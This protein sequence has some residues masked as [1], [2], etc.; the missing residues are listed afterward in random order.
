MPFAAADGLEICYETFDNRDIGLS[1]K[2]ESGPTPKVAAAMSGDASSAAYRLADMADAAGLLD[3]LGI[4]KAHI[5]G[6][7]MGGMIVQAI[8]IKHLDRVLSM[9]SIMSTTGS[10]DVGQASPEVLAT[11][12]TRPAA[13][14]PRATIAATIRSA[15]PDSWS[16]SSPP[17]TVPRR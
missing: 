16:R 1:S 5:V 6:A 3:A 12:V 15:W 14:S 13:I 17:A 10:P 11:L 7:S 8:A 4:P 2:I 9:A